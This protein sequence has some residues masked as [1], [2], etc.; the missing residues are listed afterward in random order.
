M[1]AVVEAETLAV[2]MLTAADAVDQFGTR[3]AEWLE[4]AAQDAYSVA[5]VR[6]SLVVKS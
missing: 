5:E 1:S 2:S 4:V 6:A 3:T